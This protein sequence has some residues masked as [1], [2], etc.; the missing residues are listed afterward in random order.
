MRRGSRLITAYCDELLRLLFGVLPRRGTVLVNAK[1]SPR[2]PPLAVDAGLAL[3]PADRQASGS[4]AAMT[5]RENCTVTD[6]RRL[7]GAVGGSAVAASRRRWD[8]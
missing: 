2:P 1:R 6:L 8:E 7:S 4:V 5:V 3:A